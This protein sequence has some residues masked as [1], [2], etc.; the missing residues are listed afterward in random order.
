MANNI[1]TYNVSPYYDDFSPDKNYHRVLFRPGYAVQAR[2]LTQLQTILQDQISKFGQHVFKEGSRVLDG[3]LFVET[4]VYGLRLNSTF[5]GNTVGSTTTANTVNATLFSNSIATGITSRARMRIK[6]VQNSNSTQEPTILI[7]SLIRGGTNGYII[8]NNEVIRFNDATTNTVIGYA[9]SAKIG[10]VTSATAIHV[11]KGVYFVRGHMVQNAAQTIAVSNTSGTPNASIG[12]R[13]TEDI[14]TSA[15]DQQLLDPAQG[16]YNYS[17]PGADRYRIRLTLHK[18]NIGSNG[19]TSN[20][21]PTNYFELVR[22]VEGTPRVP[23][24][25]PAYASLLDTM[26]KRTYDESGDYEIRPFRAKAIINST[27]SANLFLSILPGKAVVR[28]YPIEYLV[29][30]QVIVAKGRD[31]ETQSGYDVGTYYGNYLKVTALANG[32]FTTANTELVELHNVSGRGALSAG[33]K[34]GTAYTSAFKYDSGSGNTAVHILHLHNI[35]MLSG[36]TT[37]EIRSVISGTST[38]VKAFANIASVGVYSNGSTQIFDPNYTSYLFEIPHDYVKSVTSAEYDIRRVFQNVSFSSGQATIL[39]DNGNERFLGATSGA[40]PSGVIAS[41][42]TVIT[43]STS[44]TF[45]KGKH[46]PLDTGGRSVTIASVASGSPGQATINLNNATFNGTCDII[47]GIN[48]ENNVT[49]KPGIRTKTRVLNSSKVFR[50]IAAN[51]VYSLLKSDIER[52]NAVYW[53]GSNTQIPTATTNNVSNILTRFLV[54]DGQRD[55][56]Y[57]HG[58]LRLL[59]GSAAPNGYINVVF[60]H[61]T[62]SGKGAFTVNSYPV[63]YSN[64]GSYTTS[65]GTVIRLTDAFDFRARRKDNSSNTVLLFDTT[66]QLPDYTQS[67]DSDYEY[68]LSRSDKLALTKTGKF[69]VI[70]GTPSYDNPIPPADIDDAMT[71]A[72]LKIRPFT[73]DSRDVN[74]IY[75]DNRRFTMRDIGKIEKRVGRIEYYTA[76]SLLEKDV[77]ALTIKDAAGNDMFKNGILVDNF[78]GHN[79]ADVNNPD[80]KA[81]IDYVENYARPPFISR[82]IDFTVGTQTGVTKTSDLITLPYTEQVAFKQDLASTVERINPFEVTSWVGKLTLSP[83]NDFWFDTNAQPIVASNEDGINDNWGQLPFFYHGVTQWNFWDTNWFFVGSDDNT[84]INARRNERVNQTASR[85][86]S[87]IDSVRN[88]FQSS[89][90]TVISEATVFPFMRK[91]TIK[92]DID[93]MRPNTD[94]FCWFGGKFYNPQIRVG[95]ESANLGLIRLSTDKNGRANGYIEIPAPTS[96]TFFKLSAG[97]KLVLFSDDPYTPR[98]STTWAQAIYTA[99]GRLQPAPIPAPKPPEVIEIIR[100]DPN[101]GGEG[102]GTVVVTQT[103]ID[104]KETL[105]DFITAVEAQTGVSINALDASVSKEQA[106]QTYIDSLNNL[107]STYLVSATDTIDTGREKS[108]RENNATTNLDF[109][110]SIYWISQLIET[111]GTYGFEQIENHLLN[112]STERKALVEKDP[113]WWERNI[114]G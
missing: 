50:N 54:D 43:K 20:N 25:E 49:L 61:Y 77:K 76:L 62:H 51:T 4:N 68:Y 34:I 75:T 85:D 19:L 14:V 2:E 21:L 8:A 79:V 56:H 109:S 36:N 7:A 64:I 9:N 88:T 78:R 100:V 103:F 65:Q 40:V 1:T 39:T 31:T 92:F 46:I 102:N 55:S 22:L 42:Y 35:Q 5:G 90:H 99:Q 104:A 86:V 112:G 28:G 24:N 111:N 97:P 74:L 16:S 57:D 114:A 45:T 48:I 15:D 37:N 17:A 52:I 44:G 89:N 110:G 80:Y 10:A 93:G 69:I 26:A 106:A 30:N 91:N 105:A 3:Q 71:V 83:D 66:T 58:N 13:Y 53:A 59:V 32:S 96:N 29:P 47:A 101:E 73:F 33:T 38:N 72:T 41:F 27:S 11:D 81:S 23:I 94:I 70:S 107:Y 87:G 6:L 108:K 95:S 84:S 98:F 60:N 18:I 82:A 63:A 113:S 12:F 67:V